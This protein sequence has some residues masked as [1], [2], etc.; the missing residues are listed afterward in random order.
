MNGELL[1]VLDYMEREKGINKERLI[2]AVEASLLSASRKTLGNTKNIVIKIDRETGNIKAF[3]ELAVVELVEDSETQISLDDAKKLNS[4]AAVGDLIRH[5]ITPKNFGRIAAQTA[6]Q[7]IIQKIREAER[8]IV[9]AEF[10]GRVGDITSGVVRRIEHGDVIVDLG[11]TEALLP[12]KERA[13][14]EDYS[15]G[16]RVRVY[17]VEV[18]TGSR[19]PEIIVSRSH[20]GLIKKLFA[21]EVPEISEGTVEIKGIAREPGYRAK[22][23]IRSTDEKVDG[24]G[25]CVGMRGARVKNIV[26]ELNGEKID[27][28]KWDKDIAQYVTNSLS[29]AELKKVNVFP[30]EKTVEVLVKED[31]L[32]LAIGKRGQNARLTAKLTGWKINIKKEVDLKTLKE[33]AI[34]Q[35][36][37]LEGLTPEVA[38]KLVESGFTSL[39]SLQQADAADLQKIEGIDAEKSEQIIAE[40]KKVLSE[41]EKKTEELAAASFSPEDNAAQEVLPESEET[42]SQEE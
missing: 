3:S 11:K 15:V 24:V 30:E 34:K 37:K 40:A 41:K 36:S 17:I 31:Q 32:A 18:R 39:E 25:A 21:L 14:K 2:E 5:E 9:Y 38:Q 27:I 10:K 22:I 33:E 20:P 19:G 7:V 16:S 28:V 42:D 8:E 35:I 1:S 6:K 23:A 4:N 12:Y 26:R 29:P 13:P